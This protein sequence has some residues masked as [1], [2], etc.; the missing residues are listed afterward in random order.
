[1]NDIKVAFFVYPSAFQNIGG[2]EI[3]L[4]KTK[5]Y[6]E[7]EGIQCKL[8]DI[9]NDKLENFDILHVIG[10][11][12]DCL[13]LMATAKNKGV[14]VVLDP[15]FFSTFQR[16]FHE[17]GGIRRKTEA[18]LRHLVKIAIPYFPSARR[19]MML[20][21]DA[22]IPN[23]QIELK[24]L[25]K[26]FGISEEKMFVIPNCVDAD[27]EKGDRD[28]FITKFG[29]RDFILSV[30]RIEPRKNQ[31]NLIRAARS[32]KQ[33]L[34]MIGNPV[35]DYMDY[36]KECKKAGMGKVTFIG[37]IDHGDPMLKSAYKACSCFVSQG[38][39]ETPGLA[40]LEAG[41]A[42][43]R[44]ASTDK[45]CTREYFKGFVEYFDP[46]DISS[47]VEALERTLSKEKTGA[48]QLYIKNNLLWDTAARKNIE[49]YKKI[50]PEKI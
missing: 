44:V 15:V 49:V 10:A 7:K 36:Y 12:K 20:I 48:F 16:A 9:W 24:Q 41:L 23:S 11:V 50:L 47:I 25:K 2:G 8:F 38:W 42:G 28:L 5:E 37:G 6:L 4:L 18:C 39:F 1:M 26:L 33:P 3:L 34:V 19:K 21:S 13:G 29:I 30:G 31:L 40:A 45:G 46:A 17:D 32:F 35:S 43:A 27:F 22:V 14:K